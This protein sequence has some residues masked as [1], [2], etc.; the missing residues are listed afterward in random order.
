MPDDVC[1][2][3]MGDKI[4]YHETKVAV[5]E[6]DMG[7][8]KHE[9]IAIN[10]SLTTL[11]NYVDNLKMFKTQLLTGAA[12][13]AFVWTSFVTIDKISVT[14]ILSNNKTQVQHEKSKDKMDG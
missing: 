9:L 4:N 2:I 1:L 8:I 5:I 13:I 12:I 6:T 10:T 7:H 11:I 14:P 3:K